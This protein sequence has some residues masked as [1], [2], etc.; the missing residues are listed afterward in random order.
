M[1]CLLV[2]NI[3][4]QGILQKQWESENCFHFY[5]WA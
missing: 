2:N 5:I 1:G 4:E 3:I